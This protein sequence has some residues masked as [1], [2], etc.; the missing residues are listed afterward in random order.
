ML[1]PLRTLFLILLAF[2]AG[3]LTERSN[4]KSACADAGGEVTGGVC[5]GAAR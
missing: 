5:L 1:R 2:V 4:Q 3:I